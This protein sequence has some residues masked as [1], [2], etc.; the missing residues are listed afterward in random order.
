MKETVMWS[1]LTNYSPHTVAVVASTRVR[2]TENVAGIYE[3]K[4]TRR[5]WSGNPREEISVKN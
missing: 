1:F 5:I 4:V 2:W 3:L